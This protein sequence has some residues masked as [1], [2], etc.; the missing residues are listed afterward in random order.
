MEEFEKIIQS[1]ILPIMSGG[2]RLSFTEALSFMFLMVYG[3]A[4]TLSVVGTIVIGTI[5]SWGTGTVVGYVSI[6]VTLYSM[7]TMLLAISIMLIDEDLLF[8]KGWTVEGQKLER[9]KITRPG[10]LVLIILIC[11]HFVYE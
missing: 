10:N 9:L 5:L 11:T 7:F 1:M 6:L 8:Y 2:E 3:V 4:A